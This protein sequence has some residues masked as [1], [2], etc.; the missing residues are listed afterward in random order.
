MIGYERIFNELDNFYNDNRHSS[1]YP[2]YDM[3]KDGEFNFIIEIALA[4]FNKDDI[5]VM[6]S[7]NILSIKSLKENKTEDAIHKGISYR[8]FTR[9]FSLAEDIIVNS[10]D[11][12]NGLLTIKLER[13]IPEE[14]KP[15]KIKIG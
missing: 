2:P 14:K 5:E 10:A 11:L 4:G 12:K 9:K 1:G 13:V 6:V 8:K 7:D 15:R 3:R